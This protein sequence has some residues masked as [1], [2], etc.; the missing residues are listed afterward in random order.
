MH[1]MGLKEARS[2]IG[3]LGKEPTIVQDR[4]KNCFL[5]IPMESAPDF[6]LFQRKLRLQKIAESFQ[7]DKT[8]PKK[9]G[10]MDEL[11]KA[12]QG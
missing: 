10:T 7:E 11:D 12:L 8:D 1:Y 5:A 6:L 4:G 9:W 3:E 2:I